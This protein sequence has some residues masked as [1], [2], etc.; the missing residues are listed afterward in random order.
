MPVRVDQAKAV[1]HIAQETGRQSIDANVLAKV[2]NQISSESA[3][4]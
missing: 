2:R 3:L 4:G 1:V